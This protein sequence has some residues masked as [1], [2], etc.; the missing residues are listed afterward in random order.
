MTWVEPSP[1]PVTVCHLRKCLFLEKCFSLVVTRKGTL[2]EPFFTEPWQKTRLGECLWIQWRDL[3]RC[4]GV[5][6]TPSSRLFVYSS[7]WRDSGPV[8]LVIRLENW[9]LIRFEVKLFFAVT[10]WGGH[11]KKET[12][13][14][15]V[16][17]CG[18]NR[19]PSP[20]SNCSTDLRKFL[21]RVKISLP[22]VA[23]IGHPNDTPNLHAF[24][25]SCHVS[26]S[27]YVI[28]TNENNMKFYSTIRRKQDF[29]TRLY[30]LP[31]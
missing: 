23:I 21:S 25:E 27:I 29:H 2:E 26:Y 17:K 15:G 10:N 16:E 11:V 12:R 14:T 1:V 28:F 13:V 5:T 9:S 19:S 22:R 8:Y 30:G 24:P 3:E 18:K 7:P 31:Q 4:Q 20:P 6:S